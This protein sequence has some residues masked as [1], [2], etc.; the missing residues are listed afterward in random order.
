[1]ATVDGVLI[2]AGPADWQIVQQDESGVA[3]IALAGRWVPEFP[4]KPAVVQARLVWQDSQEPVTAAHDWAPAET[5]ADGTWRMELIGVPAG[6]LYRLETRLT[7][8]GEA[9]EWGV[10]GDMRHC[11]GVGDVWV[12]A[13]QSNAVGYGRGPVHDPPQLGVHAF[14][15]NDCWSLATHPLGDSTGTRH[16]VNRE[17]ANPA[18]APHLEFGRL[19]QARLGY[20]IGLIPTALGGSPLSE[21]E[22]KGGVPGALMANMVEMVRLAG[23]RVRGMLWYQGES[24]AGPGMAE[25]YAERFAA[26]VGA[27]RAAL[28]APALPILTVQLNRVHM[29]D[30]TPDRWWSVMRE[31]QRQVARN[32]PGVAVISALDLPVSDLIH[33]AG[34]GNMVLAGRLANAAL[35]A[36]HGRAV[37]YRAPDVTRAEWETAPRV[38]RL[39]FAHVVSRMDTVKTGARCFAVEDEDGAVPLE[40]ITYPGGPHVRL[41]LARDARGTVRVQGGQGAAPDVPAMDISR[42]MPM[43]GF[44]GVPVE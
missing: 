11:L 22:C 38:V 39:T 16:E 30:S 20:P 17:R 5:R 36:V 43:L 7:V 32:V 21:W 40:A 18:H 3:A 10:R 2:E 34:P 31:A 23:G 15:H 35:G 24:D 12:I 37:A 42:Q 19:L 6:G 33:T 4:Q 28:G 1:M 8:P 26:A 44:S 41:T 14:R 29:A 13:G 27:W 9:E 25:S